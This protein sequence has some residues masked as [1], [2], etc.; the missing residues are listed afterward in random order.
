MTVTTD[1]SSAANTRD[2]VIPVAPSDYGSLRINRSA[3]AVV[4]ERREFTF[5]DIANEA[6]RIRVQISVGFVGR[7]SD[8]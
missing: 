3:I 4:N 1:A 8:A 2:V 7:I 6:F 5:T